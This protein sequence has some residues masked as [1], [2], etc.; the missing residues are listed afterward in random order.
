MIRRSAF[1]V[2]ILTVLITALRS[3]RGRTMPAAI[4]EE[5]PIERLASV[6]HSNGTCSFPAFRE[7]RREGI[8]EARFTLSTRES[9]FCFRP[10]NV[11][12]SDS[13]LEA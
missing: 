8:G 5:A 13:L 2:S 11:K 3:P 6:R 9:T 4:V 1:P 7:V 10:S 12:S